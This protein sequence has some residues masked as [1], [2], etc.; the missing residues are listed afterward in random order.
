MSS[1]Q[2]L[3]RLPII[4]MA[5]NAHSIRKQNS[6]QA[7]VSKFFPPLSLQLAMLPPR[8]EVQSP[9]LFTWWSF[10]AEQRH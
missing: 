10:A 6:V 8:L 2:E 3:H 9:N 1:S 7:L 4:P 5:G